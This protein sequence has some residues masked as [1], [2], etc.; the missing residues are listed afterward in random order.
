MA[1]SR[2]PLR[3]LRLCVIAVVCVLSS[4]LWC[5]CTHLSREGDFWHAGSAAVVLER[6]ADGSVRLTVAKDEA[7]EEIIKAVREMAG[8]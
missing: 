1:E 8:R 3:S 2:N 4:A 7:V 5:S 6:M